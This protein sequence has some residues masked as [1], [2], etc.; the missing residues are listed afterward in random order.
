MQGPHQLAQKLM[1][2]GLPRSEASVVRGGVSTS[3]GRAGAGLLARLPPPPLVATSIIASAPA[4]SAATS[5][6]RRPCTPRLLLG[7]DRHVVHD[8]G[9]GEV[10]GV[11]RG[12][13][14]GRADTVG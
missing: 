10:R 12:A 11:E 6:Y 4:T 7:Q 14:P 5:R 2:A 9:R 8:L 3:L 1:T 13:V